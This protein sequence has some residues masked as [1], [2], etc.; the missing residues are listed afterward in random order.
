MQ[1]QGIILEKITDLF[2][3]TSR[4]QDLNDNLYE[5]KH[6]LLQHIIEYSQQPGYKN[7]LLIQYHEKVS[8][9]FDTLFEI[10]KNN[11]NRDNNGLLKQNLNIPNVSTII[12]NKF[13]TEIN[14]IIKNQF[15]EE[16]DS[17]SFNIY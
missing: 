12:L 10:W 2:I 16:I 14:K 6:H 1:K 4:M 5:I 11:A 3:F 13:N 15:P 7:N 17:K 8:I 9:D